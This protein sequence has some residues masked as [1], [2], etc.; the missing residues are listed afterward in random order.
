MTVVESEQ[1]Q[2]DIGEVNLDNTEDEK[3]IEKQGIAIAAQDVGNNIKTSKQEDA[4]AEPAATNK[5]TLTSTSPRPS[6]V[7]QSKAQTD[8]IIRL[9]RQSFPE[10]PIEIEVNG[11]TL[12]AQDLPEEMLEDLNKRYEQ[13][14]WGS[15]LASALLSRKLFE[16]M[17]VKRVYGGYNPPAGSKRLQELLATS[18]GNN[19]T[20]ASSSIW[21]CPLLNVARKTRM[22]STTNSTKAKKEPTTSTSSQNDSLAKEH[23]DGKTNFPGGGSTATTGGVAEAA[24]AEQ[25]RRTPAGVLRSVGEESYAKTTVHFPTFRCCLNNFSSTTRSFLHKEEDKNEEV[26]LCAEIDLDDVGAEDYYTEEL[27]GRA[28]QRVD[29]AG[30]I[31]AQQ[32]G[33]PGSGQ[34]QRHSIRRV[35]A[36]PKDSELLTPTTAEIFPALQTLEEVV[37][38]QTSSRSTSGAARTSDAEDF[39]DNLNFITKTFTRN[40]HTAFAHSLKAMAE[41]KK[42]SLKSSSS[43]TSNTNAT[44][45]LMAVVPGAAGGTG[46]AAALKN[47]EMNLAA[48]ATASAAGSTSTAA[49]LFQQTDSSIKIEWTN[50][51]K[52]SFEVLFYHAH[53]FHLLRHFLTN[54]DLQFAFSLSKC[55]PFQVT[56]GKSGASFLITSNKKYLLKQMNKPEIKWFEKEGDALLWYYSKT[57]FEQEEILKNG[58]NDD[59]AL[60]SNK[61][62]TTNRSTIFPS[63]LTPIYGVFSVYQSYPKRNRRSF[64]VLKNLKHSVVDHH[65]DHLPYGT[66]GTNMSRSSSMRTNINSAAKDST[67]KDV[68]RPRLLARK[69]EEVRGSV[70]HYKAFAFDLKGVGKNRRQEEEIVEEDSATTTPPAS[71]AATFG[72]AGEVEKSYVDPP[73]NAPKAVARVAEQHVSLHP[74]LESSQ[75]VEEQMR[76]TAMGNYTTGTR[77]RLLAAD[78]QA[79]QASEMVLD[80]EAQGITAQENC[81]TTNVENYTTTTT[82]DGGTETTVRVVTTE[83][84]QE[85]A[86][87]ALLTED[88]VLDAGKIDANIQQRYEENINDQEI[89]GPTSTPQP[90]TQLSS[91]AH[92]HED[93]E[94]EKK[95]I[96]LNRTAVK[97]DV[98]QAAVEEVPTTTLKKMSPPV[99]EERKSA[100]LQENETEITSRPPPPR[101]STAIARSRIDF[102]KRTL[103][104]QNFREWAQGMPLSVS[105]EDLDFLRTAIWNDTFF[106]L[107]MKLMDYSVLLLITE[108]E[109]VGEREDDG[110]G[111]GQEVDFFPTNTEQNQIRIGLIDYVRPYTLDKQV[112]HYAKVVF[113]YPQSGYQPSILD[114]AHYAQR[115]LKSIGKS[116]M[117]RVPDF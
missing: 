99:E 93:A 115:L 114:P 6:A 35:L 39:E 90:G 40:C 65:A 97:I 49:Q 98:P 29:K 34:Q 45:T 104:D 21:Q 23:K 8:D 64:M 25:E 52:H 108:G 102:P 33:R 95:G 59:A 2:E 14:D 19:K 91:V 42:K 96:L 113:N 88:V 94:E 100:P 31:P 112:E 15:I 51:K 5:S 63:I 89:D 58:I 62:R 57:L 41:M 87:N 73:P 70:Q 79:Q 38:G 101:P 69:E 26:V 92:E 36:R 82:A 84:G 11:L 47:A 103:W 81:T 24:T 16:Q 44:S 56:G 111:G 22:T 46:A 13:E 3:Q 9:S 86:S 32:D 54:G 27:Q 48:V 61:T 109:D 78:D 77:P 20:T 53:M 74:V 60:P 68:P 43:S 37:A 7:E 72:T 75:V 85:G 12:L 55:D 10:D 83:A 71:R 66:S 28:A 107:K 116:F 80:K 105:K 106:L 4:A 76:T 30:R 17:E 1:Q 67:T 50:E 18:T 117:Q 110:D